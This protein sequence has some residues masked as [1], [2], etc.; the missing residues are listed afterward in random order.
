MPVSNDEGRIVPMRLQK[1]L[2]RA[3]VASRRGS[4]DLMTAGRVAVN[5]KV[6]VELG[7]KVDPLVDVVEVDGVRVGLDH[8]KVYLV[9]NKPE[10]VITTMDDPRGRPTV[11]QLVPTARYPGLF[12]VGRLDQDTTGVLL[13]TTDGDMAARLLHPSTHVEKVYRARVQGRVRESEL[14]E[15]RRGIVLDDGPTAP[16]R[17]R[18]LDPDE[19]GELAGARPDPYADYVE[20]CIH[21][22]RKRQV[23]RMLSAIG[24]RVEQLVRVSFGPLRADDLAPGAWRLLS[25]AEVAA[26]AS[27]ANGPYVGTRRVDEGRQSPTGSKREG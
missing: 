2:A 21:E 15:L 10:G 19:A 22:G 6:A 4:E 26:L 23:K 18:L 12:P 8:G 24:H 27:A 9:L 14:D 20:I 17:C 16:A 7:T 11:A 5:G 13:F 3:G 25:S 1:F